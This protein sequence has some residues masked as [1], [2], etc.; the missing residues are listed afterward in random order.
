MACLA[1]KLRCTVDM[2][3]QILN[4]KTQDDG[5]LYKLL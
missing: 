4:Y 1:K 2:L 3:S 5:K